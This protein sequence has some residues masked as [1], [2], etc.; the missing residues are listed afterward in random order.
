ME[1]EIEPP[2][3][4]LVYSTILLFCA[5][6]FS[7]ASFA[8]DNTK[9]VKNQ[10]DIISGWFKPSGP[11]SSH[12]EY[13]WHYK[14]WVNEC[15]VCH[16]HTM[17]YNPKGVAEAELTCLKCSADF[18]GVTGIEKQYNPRWRL[19]PASQP[20]ED[21]TVVEA[22]EIVTLAK[23]SRPTLLL[24]RWQIWKSKNEI[25]IPSVS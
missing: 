10:K 8:V 18:D 9:E 12:Y 1:K 20:K 16:T 25:P 15:P 7:S 6:I 2:T 3:R 4:L 19:T 23:I 24:N 13:K 17:D 21:K 22:A 11:G 14:Y 5:L